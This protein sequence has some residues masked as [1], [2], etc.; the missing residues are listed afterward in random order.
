MKILLHANTDWYLYN[1]RMNLITR[2]SELG[3][4]VYLVS[5]PGS[6]GQKLTEMGYKWFPVP[7]NRRSLNPISELRLILL[8][9]KLYRQLQ[10]DIV[11]H[12]TIKCVVYGSIAAMLTGVKCR[13]NAITGM[14]YTFTRTNSFVRLLRFILKTFLSFVLKGDNTSLIL[15]NTDD[16]ETIMRLLPGIPVDINIIRGSGVNIERFRPNFS[17]TNQ[18]GI[19]EI[20]IATRLLADK[21]IYEYIE[22]AKRLAHEEKLLFYIAGTP[23]GGNPSSISSDQIKQWQQFPNIRYLGHVDD[24]PALLNKM[25]VVVLPSYRE[26]TPKIL[27]EAAAAS[28]PIIA[29]DVPGCREVVIDGENGILIKPKDPSAIADAILQLYKDKSLCHQMGLNGRNHIKNNF[30]DSKVVNDTIEVYNQHLRHSSRNFST[31]S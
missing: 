6:Y 31:I 14:G 27:L 2:L 22:A 29:T 7:L 4:V 20:L 5:P 11:H 25:D 19:F 10:P 15:Q 12:F 8:I 21:G 23:D 26:G 17:I 9:Y 1:F 28:L 3:H 30:C 24:M 13:V 18:N 16:A